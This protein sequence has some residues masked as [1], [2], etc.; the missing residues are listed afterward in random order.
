M[1]PGVAA[2]TAQFHGLPL[3]CA[4]HRPQSLGHHHGAHRSEQQ[5]VG[6]PDRD[7]E[8]PESPQCGEQPYTQCRPNDPAGEQHQG[9]RKVDRATAPIRNGA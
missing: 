7:V 9:K 6:K 8:L 4:Q 5:Y 2:R 3:P 1:N